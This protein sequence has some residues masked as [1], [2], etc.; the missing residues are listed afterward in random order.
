MFKSAFPNDT[1]LIDALFD[2]VVTN[3]ANDYWRI[4]IGEGRK[5]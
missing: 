4:D 5:I 1:E 3:A 2:F